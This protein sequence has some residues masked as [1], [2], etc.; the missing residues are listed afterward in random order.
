M[1]SSRHFCPILTKLEISRYV[2]VKSP[3]LNF[4]TPCPAYVELSR[5]DE[6]AAMMKTV[7]FRNSA[8]APTMNL[9]R[10]FL[11]SLRCC[12]LR[13]VGD[14]EIENGCPGYRAFLVR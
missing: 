9:V 4:T 7:N 12:V 1:K 3:I 10:P 2:F 8:N 14:D 11:T 5:A 13:F 6:R